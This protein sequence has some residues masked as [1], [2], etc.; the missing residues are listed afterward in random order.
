MHST[1]FFVSSI[2]CHHGSGSAAVDPS[3]QEVKPIY[4]TC[5][6]VK[7]IALTVPDILTD[8]LAKIIIFQDFLKHQEVANASSSQ[9]DPYILPCQDFKSIACLVQEL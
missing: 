3:I 7:S 2:L 4:F 6:N 8:L 9:K 1:H 5:E